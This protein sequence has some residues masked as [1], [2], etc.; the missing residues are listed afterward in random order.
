LDQALYIE[1]FIKEI[2]IIINF[3]NSVET[4][5]KREKILG[6]KDLDEELFRRN[7]T[8]YKDSVIPIIDF[9]QKY[10][11]IRTINSD[12]SENEIYGT[13]KE[14][15]FPE[16]Y[17]LVGKKYS[18]K[19]EIS[20][21]LSER[22]GMKIIDFMEFLKEPLIA[23][24]ANDDEY[25]IKQFINKLREEEDKR[26]I[27]EDFPMKKEYYTIFVQNCK[28]FKKIFYL[29][30]DNNECS[31]RMRRLGIHHKGYIGCS[32]LNK[33]LTEFELKK[34]HLEF[35]KK[36]CG[37]NFVELNVNKTFTLV[38]EDLMALICPSILI[39]KNDVSGNEI[40]NNLLN[41]FR[42]KLNYQIIDV[43]EILKEYSA[44]N[45][46][47]GKL[48]EDSAKS[49]QKIVPN[50]VKI[51]ALKPIIFNE[52][53]DKFILINYPDSV[54]AIK[55]FEEKVCKVLRYVFVSKTFPLELKLEKSEIE[56]YFKKNNRFFIYSMDD[57]NE[58]VI[59]DILNVNRDFNIAYGLP[60]AGDALINS[61]LEKN[62][63]HK[64]I[65]LVKYIEQI[66]ISK[67]GP[68]GDPESITVDLNMLLTEFKNY[69][70][71]I[72]KNQKISVE[73]LLNPVI[74]DL[75]AV[76]KFLE[77]LGRP[78]YFFEIFCNEVALVDKFKAKNEIAEDLNEEQKAEFEKNQEIP[79]KIIDLL[80]N[81]AYKTVK[82]DTS[83]SEWKSLNNFDYNF[84]RNL[85]V[86]KH[87]YSLN[88]DNSLYMIAAANKIL[89][90]NV[91]YLIYKQ[92]YLHNSWKEKLENSYCKKN[93]A[94]EDFDDFERRIY[95]TYN[96]LHFSESVVNE[97]IL[98]YIT[99]N[100]KENEDNDNIVIL[101]G[102]LNYDLL[103]K[104]DSA[105][106][107][108]IYEIKKLLNIGITLKI[109]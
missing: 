38:V 59:D 73:N 8:Q 107:L 25:V 109:I 5:I 52:K 63:K 88:I 68:E 101:S 58:Y 33:L 57:I 21:V 34:D 43:D 14:N 17:C 16:I 78:R 36:K 94:I 62:Y 56:I 106:N 26:V 81:Y 99:E 2:K 35:L 49:G 22:T 96:P 13:L 82:I 72:P 24:K 41:Y 32:E 19:T 51:E 95:K 55:E 7:F 100:S 6:K 1:R 86:I 18:G 4:S 29:N 91:P 30:A 3:E 28:N 103:P 90:V 67:A 102:Y 84:G 46:S 61:H 31:E 93:L 105:F 65:D 64:V 44:R 15:L 12:L 87:D 27:I 50:T 89:Y 23:K 92:F 74:T 80:K 11:V 85:I 20:K 108:P 104:D 76:T 75:D 77:I 39:L 66:K 53:N 48:I 47:L 37:K 98:N 60:F 71:E 10:G 97:L 70:K 42:E 45:H 83:F 69:V 9:Y 79:K 54:E 40:Q